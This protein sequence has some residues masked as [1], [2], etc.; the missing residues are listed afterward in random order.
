MADGSSDRPTILRELLISLA[1]LSCFM[2]VCRIYARYFLLRIPGADDALAVVAWIFL[3]GFTACDFSGTF[4]GSG[5][6]GDKVSPASRRTLMKIIPSGLL[7]YFVASGLIRLS[8]AAFLPRL[9]RER[10]FLLFVYALS[11]GIV[12]ITIASFLTYCFQC[13][14]VVALWI[15]K[16]GGITCMTMKHEAAL[17]NVHGK[18]CLLILLISFPPFRVFPSLAAGFACFSL[19]AASR[20]RGTADRQENVWVQGGAGVVGGFLLV[21][22]LLRRAAAPRA[23]MGAASKHDVQPAR[24]IFAIVAGVI[25][26][27]YIVNKNDSG[28]KKDMTHLV[29]RGIIWTNLEAHCGL[30][31]ACAP[32]LQSLL[33][34]I[35]SPV[36]VVVPDKSRRGS[37]SNSQS[38]AGRWSLRSTGTSLSS[39]LMRWWWRRRWGRGGGQGGGGEQAASDLSRSS[40]TQVASTLDGNGAE[41]ASRRASRWW[42][43]PAPPQGHPNSGQRRG[44]ADGDG[45]Y[46]MEEVVEGPSAK[47]LERGDGG[48]VRTIVLSQESGSRLGSFDDVG[49]AAGGERERRRDSKG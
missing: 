8:I 17:F 42:T 37:H 36:P 45:E 15:N 19:D 47:D 9:N 20:N 38:T 25:R 39:F 16:K 40:R 49:A 34:Q 3:L 43:P 5:Q 30:W 18:F 22:H 11:T 46:E 27:A 21:R 24:G 44:G 7:L 35:P 13:H 6:R 2:M 1:A 48:I 14:P 23:D 12:L 32:A 41:A 31:V 10:R 29:F 26:F 33:R 4:Y 28:P